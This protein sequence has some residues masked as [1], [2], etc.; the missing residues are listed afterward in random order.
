M[1]RLFVA[2]VVGGA[3]FAGAVGLAASLDVQPAFLGAGGAD[4]VSCDDAVQVW[5]NY[6]YEDPPG[7]VVV[8]HA[9]VA[10]INAAC[11][12]H[13][14]AVWLTHDGTEIAFDDGTV[15]SGAFSAD[16][17]GAPPLASEVNDVHVVIA[18]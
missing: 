17:T 18:N 2:V 10:G 1:K 15:T 6:G 12:G 5:W 9:N 3:L 8:R 13:D 14:I 16:F 4:V 11:N 7:G